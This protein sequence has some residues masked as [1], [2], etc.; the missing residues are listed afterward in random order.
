METARAEYDLRPPAGP[1]RPGSDPQAWRPRNI[2]AVSNGFDTTIGGE[3]LHEGCRRLGVT[4][5]GDPLLSYTRKAIGAVTVAPDGTRSW[6]KVSAL[7]GTPSHWERECELSPVV[8][9]VPRPRLIAHR[10][11]VTDDRQWLALQTTLSKSP[12][13]EHS[14]WAGTR[15]S[16]VGDPWITQLRMA[17][18][19]VAGLRTQ[20]RLVTPDAVAETIRR[21]FGPDVPQTADRWTVAHGDLSWSNITTPDLE[22]LDWESWGLA[23]HGFDAAKLVAFSCASPALVTRLERAFADVLATPS[24]KVARLF[25]LAS[26]LGQMDNGWLNPD[27]RDSIEAMARRVLTPA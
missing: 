7:R 9:G 27:Y 20:R 17:L 21:Q 25:V 5:F 22:L 14:H 18:A 15:A 12:V 1:R 24:G 8:V 26:I 23:P 2:P 6:V 13:V 19:A 11:W 4:A 3:D 10:A 16:R